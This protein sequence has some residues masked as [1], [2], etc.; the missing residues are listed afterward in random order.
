MLSVIS[1]PS[2]EASNSNNP[3][4][5]YTVGATFDNASVL[6]E[7]KGQPRLNAIS[8]DYL[9][10]LPS[11]EASETSSKGFLPI[12]LQLKVWEMY[13]CCKGEELLQDK[14]AALPASAFA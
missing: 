5:A 1:D 2:I 14:V 4:P 12:L 10:S 8:I 11:R 9:L 3:V 7:V 13:L 6:V